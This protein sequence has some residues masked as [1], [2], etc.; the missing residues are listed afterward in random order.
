MIA[1]YTK[2]DYPYNVKRYPMEMHLVHYKT[3]YGSVGE[4]I[5]HPDGLAVLS[6]LFVI[7][8]HDNPALAPVISQL[9]YTRHVGE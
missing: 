4:G 7:S 8:E 6:V 3:E 5:N 9:N 2:S 1:I